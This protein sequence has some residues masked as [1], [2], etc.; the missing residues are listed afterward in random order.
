MRSSRSNTTRM[1]RAGELLRGGQPGRA[2]ADDCDLLAGQLVR[3][4]RHHPALVEGVVDDLD[5]DLLDG[6]RILVDAEHARSLARR[7]HSRPVNSGK[8]LVACSRSIASRQRSLRTRS[9]H[10]GIRLPGHPLWQNGIPQSM[11]RVACSRSTSW[12]NS[13]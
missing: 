4:Q 11:H 12:E 3:W 10:S 5:L 2:R 9:F 8:L 13:S 6:D 1:T 7:G